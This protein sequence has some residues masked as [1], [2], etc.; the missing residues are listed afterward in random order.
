MPQSQL[1]ANF[2]SFLPLSA[3]QQMDLGVPTP[4]LDGTQTYT[5]SG[6]FQVPATDDDIVVL[7][8]GNFFSFAFHEKRPRIEVPG[9][10]MTLGV[11]LAAGQF[12]Q[13]AA[14]YTP[15]AG[16]PTGSL[17]FFVDGALVGTN[18]VT[19]SPGGGAVP[20]LIVGNAGEPVGLRRLW[21]TSTAVPFDDDNNQMVNT[22]FGT[23]GSAPVSQQCSWDWGQIPAVFDGASPPTPLNNPVQKVLTP[24]LQPG[25]AG[26]ATFT[27]D[28]DTDFSQLSIQGW[29]YF[30]E[31][32]NHSLD[33]LAQ[34][35]I[36][37]G[38]GP[39]FSLTVTLASNGTWEL[40]AGLGSYGFGK[41]GLSLSGWHNIALTWA[42]GVGTTTGILYLD[43]QL[44]V[45]GG[46]GDLTGLVPSAVTI[47]GP[48]LG[49]TN[50]ASF[51]GVIQ[52]VTLW[53][54]VVSAGDIATQ[55]Q[56]WFPVESAD[57]VAAFNFTRSPA[58]DIV[59]GETL[60][61]QG[62]ATLERTLWPA[63]NFTPPTTMPAPTPAPA[64]LK[65]LRPQKPPAPDASVFSAA[66]EAELAEA[67][68][69]ILAKAGKDPRAA[70]LE[71]SLKAKLRQR[72]AS[73]RA[74]NP[75]L[76]GIV[77]SEKQGDEWITFYY[78]DNGPEAVYRRTQ[79]DLKKSDS[80]FNWMVDFTATSLF[81][82]LDI[83]G[84]PLATGAATKALEKLLGKAKIWE[85]IGEVVE[86][87]ITT[88]SIIDVVK[89]INDGGGMTAFVD[90][91]LDNVSWWDFAFMVA[92]VILELVG[93]LVPGLEETIILAKCVLLLVQ[94]LVVLDHLPAGCPA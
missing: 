81:G 49:V 52:N 24:G 1:P 94:L 13:L 4:S 80:C 86:S 9:L 55:M 47:G 50:A 61:F 83:M 44:L 37:V 53:N 57:P 8:Q 68:R 92:Q 69:A 70:T 74:G 20:H 23:T 59:T 75:D 26:S 64:S 3:G 34:T 38:S 66:R 73:G 42:G 28:S 43:G 19:P 22:R 72:F 60:F 62:T 63:S 14:V 12:H 65:A 25:G 30:P 45:Q 89:A 82:L 71:P 35:L 40:L 56:P 2:A 33:N 21:L 39:S 6:W 91:V 78:G 93:L 5:I 51:C 18:T 17:S 88:D 7:S 11:P 84:I 77:H 10:Q 32:P 48:G 90:A 87:T 79:T 29:F 76:R 27:L 16:T 58:E 67:I 41:V 31:A 15:P 46:Q 54:V 36:Q 85:A